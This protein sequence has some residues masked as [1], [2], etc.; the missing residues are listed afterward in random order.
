MVRIEI[1]FKGHTIRGELFDGSPAVE[2]LRELLPLRV[3]GDRWG[4]EFYGSIPVAVKVE[5]LSEVVER[6]DL[7][8]WPP[9]RALCIFWGP[10]PASRGDE[11]R[12]A[13]P[14]AVIGKLE[15]DLSALGELEDGDE[16][17]LRRA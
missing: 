16:V 2:V 12:P 13:S 10:T 6:G 11:I 14:V 4:D 5:G 1:S 3:R 17:L 15:G 7:A 8:Y 9:G